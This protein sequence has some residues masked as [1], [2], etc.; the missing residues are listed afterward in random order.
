MSTF[1]L[2][3]A[4]PPATLSAAGTERF[5]TT[6]D[7]VLAA[8]QVGAEWAW[9]ALYRSLAPKV[10]GY[11]ISRGA[12][13]AD[14]LVGEVFLQLA[15]NLAG[16]EGDETQFRAWVFTIAHHRLIDEHRRRRRRPA[17]TVAQVP[18]V[19]GSGEDELIGGMLTAEARALLDGLTPEQRE[20]LL[21]RV[22]A[23][24]PLEE[25]ARIVGR[26]VSAVKSLQ[27]RALTALRK[28][29]SE[30]PYPEGPVWR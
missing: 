9:T 10:R 20:V 3:G 30:D 8:A 5:G 26:P 16:F 1:S 14:D 21:L 25:V 29:L 18:E 6:F 4:A 27:H 24:L 11:L 23:D 2:P 15:R 19:A 28:K 17:V 7:G 12:Q 13:D 22:F